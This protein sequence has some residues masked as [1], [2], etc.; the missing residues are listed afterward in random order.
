MGHASVY[1][2]ERFLSRYM[3][4]VLVAWNIVVGIQRNSPLDRFH[5]KSSA[6]TQS[7]IQC[8]Q[9][10]QWRGKLPFNRKKPSAGFTGRGVGGGG[11]E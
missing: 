2:L 7:Q 6:G 3:D 5:I 1:L 4:F 9:Q 11:G 10:Q 8:P